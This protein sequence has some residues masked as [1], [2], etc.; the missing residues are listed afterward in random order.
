[1]GNRPQCDYCGKLGH[2]RSTCFKLPENKGYRSRTQRSP[3]PFKSRS[4]RVLEAAE[5][6]QTQEKSSRLDVDELTSSLEQVSL[7][8]NDGRTKRRK[9]EEEESEESEADSLPGNA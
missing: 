3:S 1:M 9:L 5:E 7:N 6:E 4:L 2:W 8:D